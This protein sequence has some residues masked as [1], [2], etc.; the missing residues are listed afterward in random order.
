MTSELD[1]YSLCAKYWG[2]VRWVTEFKVAQNYFHAG[3]TL[4]SFKEY[5]DIKTIVRLQPVI[6]D[7]IPIEVRYEFLAHCGIC[8]GDN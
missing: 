6:L 5:P 7:Q 8:L 3:G 2:T 1:F 4:C